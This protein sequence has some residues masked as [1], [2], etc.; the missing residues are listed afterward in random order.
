LPTKILFA[1]LILSMLAT[2]LARFSV[3]A[4]LRSM[5]AFSSS[6]SLLSGP[7]QK[8]SSVS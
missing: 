2:S 3:T 7:K 6:V 5:E 8:Q 4:S 1:F